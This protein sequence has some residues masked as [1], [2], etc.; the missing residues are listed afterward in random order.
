MKIRVREI[1]LSLDEDES[2]LPLLA[3][4]KIGVYRQ[5]IKSWELVKKAIDARRRTIY[6]SYTIDI[7]LKDGIKPSPECLEQPEIS[8]LEEKQPD[9]II[10]GS[11]EMTV[12]PIVV[13][14][15]P[16][17]LFAALLLARH[18]YRPVVVEQG[19]DVDSRV[20]AVERFW[21]GGQLS[22][23]SNA[24]FGEGGAGTFSDGKLT[25]RIGDYRVDY[26]LRTFVE[27]GAPPEI[28]YVKKPHVG[29]DRIRQVVKNIR[30][31]IIRLGGEFYFSA[32]LTDII[33]NQKQLHSIV[34]NNGAE[35]P[36]A[37]LV[38]AVGNSA[39]E[40]YRLL[41]GKGVS[42]VP[43][44][45]ALGVRM[46]HPQPL[47]D[48]IQYG[49]YAG[50]PRL[51]AADYQFTYKDHSTGRS[52]YT[53]CMCPG[54]TVIAAASAPGEVVVNGMSY[55]SR[56]SGLANSALVVTVN[57]ADWEFEPLG[58]VRLQHELEMKAFQMGGGDYHAPAQY[59][60][61]FLAYQPSGR[62]EHSLASY[63]PGV[64]GV[65]LWQLL[66]REI[67]EAMRRG[68]LHWGKK[69]PGFIDGDAVLT[70]VETRTS[71]PLRI[72]RD[73]TLHSVSVSGLYPCG[74]GA[75]YAGG[76][77]SAAADGLK[78]AERIISTFA[79]PRSVPVIDSGQ[80]QKGS[81]L[82]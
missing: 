76:I 58:G 28:M 46:E 10:P 34:I 21:S 1:R 5:D 26:V 19:Q 62:M 82:P 29:T 50:H 43:K 69:A 54:G 66:P 33:F 80:V 22:P 73:Q 48:R 55:F 49:E 51:P 37:A 42:L 65:N 72:E 36:C 61:D 79:A 45:F 67:A 64:T 9:P 74:E 78:V 75:G 2:R 59:V 17:G 40:T 77:V 31:E 12:A 57:P 27:F 32:R 56:D 25:T 68:L 4:G 6:F 18:G 60:R 35:I 8:L 20:Q 23:Y 16:A 70:G 81:Q 41:A 15:G 3:A 7:E 71:A 38:L 30:R 44:A 11:R 14:S 39:R 24:Q 47:I 13:G 63:R 53:F 52:V